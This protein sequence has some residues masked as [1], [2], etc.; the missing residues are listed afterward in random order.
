MKIAALFTGQGSQY[1]GMGKD[2]YDNYPLVKFR[3]DKTAEILGTDI[4]KICFEGPEE[5]LRKTENTQP[6]IYMISFIC[7][8]LLEN[9]GIKFD[10]YAGFSLGEYSAL[11]A[12]G[13]LTYED[14]VKLVQDR[15]LIMER[16]VPA[17]AG[18][19]AAVL[20]LEDSVVEE[21]CAKVKSGVVVPANY[22]CP[23]QLVISGEKAAVDEACA[24]A[25][26][27]GAKR[28]VVLNVSGPFHSP[29]LKDASVQLK[30]KLDALTFQD[31]T[32]PV[33]SNVTALPHNPEALKEMLVKQMYSPV[34]W[35]KTIENLLADGFDT[36]V[37]V[38]PGKTL[39]GFVRK[40]DRNATIYSVNNVESFEATVKALKSN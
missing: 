15:G 14:G 5:D 17:G 7:Y 32:V 4:K 27:A 30:E 33:Y 37:E 9:A 18:A 12:S 8:R 36:F 11:A 22:N 10:A 31:G 20:G 1:V 16:A 34:Q 3:M 24:L 19:M 28:A 6:A 23:G 29:M 2:L 25:T 40:I 35:R 26:E 13:R 39:A 38:G 21:V